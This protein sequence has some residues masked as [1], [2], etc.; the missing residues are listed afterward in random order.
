MNQHAARRPFYFGFVLLLAV[1]LSLLFLRIVIGPFLLALVLAWLFNPAI[2]KLEKRGIRRTSVVLM[3]LLLL[4]ALISIAVWYIFP[5]IMHQL[6]Q[7]IKTLPRA[8]QHLES[9]ILPNIT[10]YIT[11]QFGPSKQLSKLQN[12]LSTY[13]ISPELILQT[14]SLTRIIDNTRILASWVLAVVLSPVFAF[15]LMRDFRRL[16][17]KGVFLVPPDL[18]HSARVFTLQVDRTLRAV[19]RG[20][21]L[22]ISLLS[23]LYAAAFAVAGLPGGVAVGVLTGIARIIPYL[24][25]LVGSVLSFLIIIANNSPTSV[26]IGVLVCFALIQI[27]DALLL[28]PKI[29]GQFSGLHPFIII[30]SVLCFGDWFGVYGIILA[31]PLASFGRVALL[32]MLEAYR[33][34]Q[35]YRGIRKESDKDDRRLEYTD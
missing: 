12:L 9:T 16:V 18:R 30:L 11:T 26:I 34:S 35:F 14:F 20:Q 3:V 15:F 28:T 5:L 1:I 6:E 33:N 23:T 13:E 7:V 31:I 8:K 25:I 4:V 32:H 17:Q 2:E 27:C 10:K 29:M 22:V 24:D 21:L 19:V